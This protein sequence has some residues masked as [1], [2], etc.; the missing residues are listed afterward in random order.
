M[1]DIEAAVNWAVETCNDPNVGYS[2]TYRNQVTIDGITYYD[3]SSFIWYALMAGGFDVVGAYGGETWP[4]TTFTMIPVLENLGFQELS[5]DELWQAGDICVAYEGEHT[6]MVYEGSDYP[7]QG[8]TMGAHTDNY[9]LPNQV[10]INNFWSTVQEFP[11]I[12]R[13]PVPV[14]PPPPIIP[15]KKRGLKIWQMIR[16]HF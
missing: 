16:Y 1:P 3:C 2:M 13:Y 9:A 15:E 5:Y 10:S 8:I 14:P 4:F 6:E 12:F 11:Q 7:G